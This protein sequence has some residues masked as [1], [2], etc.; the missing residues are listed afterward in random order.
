MLVTSLKFE[1]ISLSNKIEIF[2]KVLSDLK[3]I[4]EQKPI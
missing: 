2:K 1:E 3:Q 4:Y